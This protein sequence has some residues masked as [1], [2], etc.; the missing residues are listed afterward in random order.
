MYKYLLIFIIGLMCFGCS[1]TN[2][3]HSSKRSLMLL[4]FYEQPRNAKFA[5]PHYQAKLHK[6][7]KQHQRDNQK[8]YRRSSR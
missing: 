6:S 1:S 4:D 7:R 2:G 5:S 8:T 3:I